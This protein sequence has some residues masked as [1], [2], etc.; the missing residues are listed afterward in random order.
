MEM[1]RTEEPIKQWEHIIKECFPYEIIDYIRKDDYM[2][3]LYWHFIDDD[4]LKENYENNK[5]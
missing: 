3:R 1:T 5:S 2:Y 4:K